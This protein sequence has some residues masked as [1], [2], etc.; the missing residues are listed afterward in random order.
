MSFVCPGPRIMTGAINGY[1]L[2][3][4]YLESTQKY[5]EA[6]G[7]IIT[8]FSLSKETII[9]ILTFFL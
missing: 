3:L 1:I 4:E 9:N 2:I 6:K 5:K 7:K 8:I